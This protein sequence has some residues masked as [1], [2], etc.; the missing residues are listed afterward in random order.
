MIQLVNH[1]EKILVIGY[2]LPDKSRRTKE[3]V[4]EEPVE[5]SA[6]D[7]GAIET[8]PKAL[9]LIEKHGVQVVNLEPEPEEKPKPKRSG[10]R[11]KKTETEPEA[12]TVEAPTEDESF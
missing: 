12:E 11:K 2:K 9:A 3:L 7:W 4:P 6:E 8:S 5:V 10:G 1:A